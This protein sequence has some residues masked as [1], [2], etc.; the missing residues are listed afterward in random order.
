M[1]AIVQSEQTERIKAREAKLLARQAPLH[2]SSLNLPAFEGLHKN[3][4]VMLYNMDKKHAHL[5]HA[6]GEIKLIV[7]ECNANCGKIMC[8]VELDDH[9]TFP[10]ITHTNQRREK[11]NKKTGHSRYGSL[12]QEHYF[13][14]RYAQIRGLYEAA[15]FSSHSP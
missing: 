14:C 9:K 11:N 12:I 10:F 6:T 3:D 5:E 8:M 4:A 13:I 7:H 2:A 1:V 15:V